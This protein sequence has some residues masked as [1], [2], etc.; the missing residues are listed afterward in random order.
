VK[1]Y[2]TPKEALLDHGKIEKIGRGRISRDNHA[3]LESEITAG[4]IAISDVTIVKSDNKAVAV[5]AKGPA[6]K[7]IADIT[8][9][10][11]K[12]AYHAI[13]VDDNKAYGMAEVCN[14]CRVSL[15]Q[16]Q[17]LN[18]T[19]LGNIPVRIIPNG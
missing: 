1:T 7:H 5:K 8:I 4:R 3:W 12:D 16:N 6:E 2:A 15:V 19:I 18:P 14:T 10:Y 13:G 11:P 17:C 9:L